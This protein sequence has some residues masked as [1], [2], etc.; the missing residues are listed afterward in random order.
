MNKILFDLS[1]CQPI[2]SSKF[3]GGGVYGYIVFQSL[4]EKYPERIGAYY[5]HQRFLP[6]NIL[7][8]LKTKMIAVYDSSK[9]SLLEAYRKGGY[10]K[11]YSP[12]YSRTYSRLIQANIPIMITIHGLRSLEMNRDKFEWLYAN[13]IRDIFKV[14]I[15]Q[16][17]LF[18]YLCNKYHAEYEQLFNYEYAT[19]V[20]VSEHSKASMKNFYPSVN[21]DNIKVRYSPNTSLRE[22]KIPLPNNKEYVEKYYLIISAN[23]WLK[24]AYRAMK[25]FDNI[26][27]RK[28]FNAK[29]YVVG[30]D[31]E[32]R[33]AKRLKHKEHYKFF[34]Y[35]KREDLEHLFENAYALVYPS[36]NEGFGYPP[37]EAMQYGVP[38]IA[39]GIASIPEICED[40]VLYFN[41]YSVN[42]I[43]NRIIQMENPVLWE[44]Y[45]KKAL[46]QYAK[47]KKRQD[48]DLE[49]LINE[50]IE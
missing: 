2:G 12:L 25:A 41:P 11:V 10:T 9:I 24:N 49:S 23:R 18:R 31:S 20:T 32:H 42:E 27:E 26:I 38:V 37:I 39:S 47:V 45:Q 43:A 48:D 46:E 22:A 33:I 19:I 6:E 30:I 50:I 36:L 13:G 28:G 44:C 14:G 4:A 17:Y 5:D 8:L 16:T 29:I 7:D 35:Q 40:A 15:K 34:P 1:V 3:H 21:V